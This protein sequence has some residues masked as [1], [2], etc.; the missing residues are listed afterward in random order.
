MNIFFTLAKKYI[1]LTIKYFTYS[2]M[3]IILFLEDNLL[4]LFIIELR[5]FRSIHFPNTYSL[6]HT[7]SIN[8]LTYLMY[9]LFGM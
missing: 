3:S 5:N 2:L 7:W 1:H 6:F 4:L 8:Y 9:C